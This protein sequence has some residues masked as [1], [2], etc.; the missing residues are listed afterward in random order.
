MGRQFAE[1]R[2][3]DKELV[4]AFAGPECMPASQIRM[5]NLF[6]RPVQR[7]FMGRMARN[8]GYREH[9]DAK[10]YKNIVRQ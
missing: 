1:T 3:F 10:P 6:G 7:I 8:M 5:F 2:Q 9:L 4:H